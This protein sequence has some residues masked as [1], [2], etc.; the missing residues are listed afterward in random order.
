MANIYYNA[1]RS[2]AAEDSAGATTG[3]FKY[4]S[5]IFKL[6]ASS[7]R[8]VD[9]ICEIS[10]KGITNIV[11][12][13]TTTEATSVLAP[14]TAIVIAPPA[15]TVN[16]RRFYFAKILALCSVAPIK[17]KPAKLSYLPCACT[18]TSG[19]ALDILPSNPESTDAKYT[20][21]T[22]FIYVPPTEAA[23]PISQT[24]AS[25]PPIRTANVP[26]PVT[27]ISPETIELA[28]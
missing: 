20:L 5:K 2:H 18:N 3:S 7:E 24:Q 22:P 14:A 10:Q 19:F 13:T 1:S 6:I 15:N 16:D 23:I 26:I 27:T 25:T 4:I 12:S 17:T 11:A 9:V 21:A 28:G 8:T